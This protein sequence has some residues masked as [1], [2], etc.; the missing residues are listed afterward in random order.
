MVAVSTLWNVNEW[1]IKAP[2]FVPTCINNSK[3]TN[4]HWSIQYLLTRTE[5]IISRLDLIDNARTCAL[6]MHYETST[7]R[8][9][10]DPSKDPLA[11]VA[12]AMR[13]FTA[14][15]IHNQSWDLTKLGAYFYFDRTT[16]RRVRSTLHVVGLTICIFG[17]STNWASLMTDRKNSSSMQNDCASYACLRRVHR[18]GAASRTDPQNLSEYKR[19]P[20]PS[21]RTWNKDG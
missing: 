20:P 9:T 12:K 2:R 4:T 1:P 5:L 6:I 16:R 11:K 10:I 21:T 14:A 17:W 15:S 13:K 18:N 3:H 7:K 19:D 8:I